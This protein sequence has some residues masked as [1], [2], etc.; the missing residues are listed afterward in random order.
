MVLCHVV[1]R[2]G[3]C[4]CRN[5]VTVGSVPPHVIGGVFSQGPNL[6]KTSV[7][8]STAPRVQLLSARGVVRVS[9]AT[10][11]RTGLPVA[12]AKICASR[13]SFLVVYGANPILQ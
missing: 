13:C 3:A 8:P 11:C 12:R 9:G 2:L 4:Q 6:I 5:V 7:I 10:Y 1:Q